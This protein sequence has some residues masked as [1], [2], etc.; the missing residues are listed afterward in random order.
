[1]GLCLWSALFKVPYDGAIDADGHINEPADLWEN[2][3]ESQYLDRAIRIRP[4]PDGLDHLELNGQR[5]RYFDA[6]ILARGRSMGNDAQEREQVRRTPYADSVPFG[7]TKPQERLE[8]LDREN[9]AV[10]KNFFAL[11]RRAG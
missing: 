7:G 11:G 6:E 10:P 9:L 5:P 8:L 1:M 4:G 2:Y 3:L